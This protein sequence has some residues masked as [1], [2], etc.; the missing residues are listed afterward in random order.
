MLKPDCLKS[1][2][3]RRRER[4]EWER[5]RKREIKKREKRRRKKKKKKKSVSMSVID[6]GTIRGDYTL[7][8]LSESPPS[9]RMVSCAKQRGPR[10]GDHTGGI[11]IS[12]YAY[13][14]FIYAILYMISGIC[15]PYSIH[16]LKRIYMQYMDTCICQESRQRTMP[17]GIITPYQYGQSPW[18]TRRG[19]PSLQASDDQRHRRWGEF[20]Q[21]HTVCTVM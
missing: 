10:T 4:S 7:Q 6:T 21:I 17:V 5:E 8:R 13:C 12:I 19:S 20:R 18:P 9:T 15:T 3:K 14:K 2:G 11:R 16:S 1:G